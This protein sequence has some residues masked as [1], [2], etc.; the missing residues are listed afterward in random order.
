ME[1]T[2]TNGFDLSLFL[3]YCW[4]IDCLIVHQAFRKGFFKERIIQENHFQSLENIRGWDF[5]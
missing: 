1:W 2:Y 4:R 3:I 5:S